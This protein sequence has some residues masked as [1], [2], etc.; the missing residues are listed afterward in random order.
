MNFPKPAVEPLPF[1][2]A[3]DLADSIQKDWVIE[4]LGGAGD[5]IAIVGSPGSG[6]SA[7]QSPRARRSM[8]Q[9]ARSESGVAF[10]P[11]R[12]LSSAHPQHGAWG[13][14]VD[15]RPSPAEQLFS[16]PDGLRGHAREPP[17]R[18]P[19][20]VSRMVCVQKGNRNAAWAPTI[21]FQFQH[22]PAR[23]YSAIRSRTVSAHGV[24]LGTLSVR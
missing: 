19:A 6:K 17:G 8:A 2:M 4:G 15:G 1:R 22:L 5:L 20:R 16:L 21:R 13:Q 14:C 12:L 9:I 3:D 23:R 10:K 7:L 24:L 11:H 18:P